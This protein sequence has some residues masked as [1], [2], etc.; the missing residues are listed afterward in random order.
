MDWIAADDALAQLNVQKQTLYA[1]VSRGLVRAKADDGDP[2]RSLY[3]ASDV[4]RLKGRRRGARRRSEVAA[5]AIAWGE[6]VLESA[7]STV[8]DGQ[9]IIRG[10]SVETL[11][12]KSTLEDMARLLW[13]ADGPPPQQP[14]RRATG[15][16]PKARAFAMLSRRVGE[17]APSLG[18][19][20][21]ALRADAWSILYDFADALAGEPGRGLLH[22][23]LA[24]SLGANAQG[25]DIIRRALVLMADH[26]L[27]PSTFA[28]RIAASTGAPLAACALA[29]LSTLA[30]P[31]HG[32]AP[33]RA[34]AQLDQLIG[35][36]DVA[37]EARTM[38]ARGDAI[39]GW[40]HP[41]YPDGDI[42]AKNLLTALKPKLAIAKALRALERETGDKP[43]CDAAL[44]AMTRSLGLSDEAT[45]S[46]FALARMTGWLAHA[47][48]QRETGRLIR[49]RA[50]YTGALPAK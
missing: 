39:A 13:N 38:I 7:I 43:N 24:R 18:R 12:A 30:G 6:P 44:A 27:N 23:R 22:Q 5:G 33:V 47:M 10:R 45:F 17:D 37:S 28:V 19:S 50:R 16:T 2:R 14:I 42:R 32:E 40:S 29:G 8:R 48:E 41:L 26:E 31:L 1:Y 20:P 25:A 49:P 34:L 11:A 35:A 9:L 4:A 36:K 46:I 3:S 21:A 15:S